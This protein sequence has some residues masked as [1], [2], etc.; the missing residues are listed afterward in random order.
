[1]AIPAVS[2][3]I[4]IY[5]PICTHFCDAQLIWT[6]LATFI[7]QTFIKQYPAIPVKESCPCTARLMLTMFRFYSHGTFGP[8]SLWPRHW[9]CKKWYKLKRS[10]GNVALRIFESPTSEDIL[11][12]A[13]A[14]YYD[15]PEDIE[16]VV[17]NLYH[18]ANSFEYFCADC[19]AP[20]NW[21]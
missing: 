19:G 18:V 9:K 11:T 7:M 3:Y 13:V 4:Y 1:M 14:I 10:G 5:I 21:V 20:T 6:G 2:L 15:R 16:A 8:F 12:F 17:G